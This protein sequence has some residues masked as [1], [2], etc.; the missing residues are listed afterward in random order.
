LSYTQILYEVSERIATITLNRPERLN[1]FTGTMGEEIHAAFQ[2]AT[3]DEAV[4][5]IIVTGAG[6]GFCSGIDMK[7]LADPL[8]REKIGTGPFLKRFPV[9][10]YRCPK[11]TICAINGA[12]VGVGVTMAVSFDYRI[13]SHDAKLS[14]PF[15][16]LGL[17]PGMAS[18][19][20]LPKLIGR[21]H[22]LEILMTGRTLSAAEAR[23]IGLVD[24]VV[25]GSELLSTARE[26]AATIAAWNPA[27]IRSIKKL[28]GAS[29]TATI[30][31]ALANEQA[32]F[33]TLSI[34][35]VQHRK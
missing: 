22:A 11:P 27:L 21:S 8:E 20:L 33:T 13:A 30:E 28:I 14:V 5:A 6:S 7:S 29:E 10:C 32:A 19:S 4:A 9:D 34:P 17:L 16:K 2:R 35:N 25:P 3:E 15:A 1:A 31:Q 26:M 24:R 18:S 12:A 23:D